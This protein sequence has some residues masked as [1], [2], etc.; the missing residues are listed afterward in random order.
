MNT[1][2]KYSNSQT[3]TTYTAA[4]PQGYKQ[5]E[6]GVIPEDWKVRIL[7]D[8]VFFINGKAHE[9]EISDYGRYTVVNSKFISSEGRIAKF[10]NSCFCPTSVDDI[11]MVMSDVPNGKAIAKCFLV[12]ERDVYTVNQRICILKPK[13]VNPDFLFYKINRNQ[14][15]LTF[16]DGVQQTN[17]RKADVLACPLSLPTDIEEQRV[18]A[19]ALSDVDGLIIALDK[20]I[21][22]KRDIKLAAMQQL[23]TGKT[24]LSGFSGE[25]EMKKLGE[26]AEIIKGS[27][28][29]KGKLEPSGNSG[30]ILYGEL[31]TIY[32]QVIKHVVSRTNSIEGRLSKYGD[33][34]MPGST[35]TVGIDLAIASALLEDNVLLGGDIII[36]RKKDNSYNSE[37]L[38]HYLT[39]IKRH[40]IAEL[41]QG[42]TII[43]MYGS[44]LIN[45]EL[46]LPSTIEEQD[47][48]ATI[49]SDMGAEIA[50]LERR[51]EKTSAIKQGM[52]QALLTGRVRLFNQEASA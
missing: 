8:I 16:D 47:A 24:R 37:F 43:H 28:L 4:I 25:W 10:S 36:L 18:I 27:G 33:V 49:L 32:K 30:C 41:A 46:K 39:Q 34:L 9:N 17:L 42:I 52:I 40:A 38:A 5:T 6:V 19:A 31:F 23:L 48:I 1:V 29:S 35:T 2:T 3:G 50:A 45:L 26:V 7:R 11:L 22:K 20:V 15:Y 44:N 51:R 21:A 13:E 12:N 14:F